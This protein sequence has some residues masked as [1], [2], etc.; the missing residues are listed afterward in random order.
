[1]K[2]KKPSSLRTPFN[3]G[4]KTV[5]SVLALTSCLVLGSGQAADKGPRHHAQGQYETVTATYVVVEGDD[6]IAISERLDISVEA[7]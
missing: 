3:T 6:L 7:G 5:F 1:M 4:L 2:L